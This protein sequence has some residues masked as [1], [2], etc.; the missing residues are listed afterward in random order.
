MDLAIQSAGIAFEPPLPPF[1]LWAGVTVP[2][3]ASRSRRTMSRG[4]TRPSGRPR[5]LLVVA[6]STIG[7][8]ACQ[9]QPAPLCPDVYSNVAVSVPAA[10][11]APQLQVFA[12]INAATAAGATG[13]TVSIVS[14]QGTVSYGGRGPF[15]AFIFNRVPFPAANSITYAGLGVENGTWFPFCPLLLRGWTPHESLQGEMTDRDVASVR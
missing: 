15:Q 13:T 10:T 2:L 7:M 11:Y 12:P 6:A 9:V 8:Y 4:H 5:R 14:N 3:Q 1:D